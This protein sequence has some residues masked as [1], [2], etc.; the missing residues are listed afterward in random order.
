MV[1]YLMGAVLS[2][3]WPFAVDVAVL[4]AAVRFYHH[5]M[6]L[7]RS[8]FVFVCLLVLFEFNH[9]HIFCG[10]LPGLTVSSD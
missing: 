9:M 2:A 3:R 5:A 6:F 1:I 7:K 8:F 4:C 10:P